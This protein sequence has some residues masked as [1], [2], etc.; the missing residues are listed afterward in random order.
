MVVGDETG[1]FD[2]LQARARADRDPQPQV[3]TGQQP[4]PGA[5]QGHAYP[6]LRRHQGPWGEEC[7]G[8]QLARQVAAGGVTLDADDDRLV[9]EWLW[10]AMGP[11][12]VGTWEPA[13]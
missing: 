13:R 10:G 8:P 7:A 11:G 4:G 5:D 9:H 3:V 12:S 1:R 2:Q 6:V